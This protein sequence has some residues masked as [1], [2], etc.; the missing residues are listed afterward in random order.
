MAEPVY[1]LVIRGGRVATVS[2]VFEADVGIT[3]E[4]IAA[5]GRNLE[6]RAWLK[7]AVKRDPSDTRGQKALYQLEHEK[8]ARSAGP[9]SRL[10]GGR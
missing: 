9:A 5:I 6:A 10:V 1:D 7:L 8:A 2:D 3:G 4:T